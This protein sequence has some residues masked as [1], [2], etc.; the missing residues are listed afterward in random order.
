MSILKDYL[1]QYSEVP[2]FFLLNAMIDWEFFL[3][4]QNNAG[5]KGGLLEIGVYRGKSAVLGAMYMKPDEPCFF[6]DI[7]LMTD[8]AKMIEQHHPLNNTYI[9]AQSSD[10]PRFDS[11][12]SQRGTLRWIHID[13]DHKGFSVA[14]DLKI[15]AELLSSDGIICVDDFFNF[16]YPQLTAAVYQF[17]F[18]RKFDFT[19]LFCGG[20]KGYICRA[21]QYAMYE[22]L[23][24]LHYI[25]VTDNLGYN[26]NLQLNKSSY[27]HD[28]GCFS[29]SAR[30]S[31][32]RCLGL[33]EAPE[34]IVY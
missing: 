2:G 12:M 25:A 4:Q 16:R 6:N 7:G 9:Q 18:E 22:R 34:E 20:N 14:Q 26:L 10:L 17:L 5:V 31:D 23:I 15:A 1:A 13:G 24:R 32:Q 30:Y 19:L 27:V 11:I 21:S 3:G 33:D 8:S 29:S 28:F